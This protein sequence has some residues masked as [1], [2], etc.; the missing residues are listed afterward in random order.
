MLTKREGVK[1]C[2]R[3]MKYRTLYATLLQGHETE[4]SARAGNIAIAIVILVFQQSF[5]LIF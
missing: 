2:G 5:I 1:C 3:S 4:N